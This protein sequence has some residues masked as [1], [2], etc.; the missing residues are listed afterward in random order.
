[1]A[2]IDSVEE[3][4]VEKGILSYLPGDLGSHRP[5]S[6]DLADLALLT[7]FHPLLATS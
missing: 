4:T 5:H 7:S 3:D 1:V 6:G 2:E